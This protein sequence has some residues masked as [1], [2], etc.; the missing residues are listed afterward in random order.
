MYLTLEGQKGPAIIVNTATGSAGCPWAPTKI[1][2]KGRGEMS[3][4]EVKPGVFI[5]RDDPR[6]PP[7]PTANQIWDLADGSPPM[8]RLGCDVMGWD[9]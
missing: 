3:I 4:L 1:A 5:E 2:Q 6:A 9:G 8:Q 7:H